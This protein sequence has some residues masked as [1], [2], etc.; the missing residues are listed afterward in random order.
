[1]EQNKE[2]KA[3]RLCATLYRV[4]LHAMVQQL[5]QS[6]LT[7]ARDIQM[8]VLRCASVP[9]R[10]LV[11]SCWRL[12]AAGATTIIVNMMMLLNKRNHLLALLAQAAAEC[13]PCAS[14]TAQALAEACPWFCIALHQQV[15]LWDV[16]ITSSRTHI[17]RSYKFASETANG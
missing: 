1:M 4:W 10:W 2:S 7:R 6:A 16:E 5:S 17:A 9:C 14:L 8:I 11:G 15:C 12:P 3:L 13:T